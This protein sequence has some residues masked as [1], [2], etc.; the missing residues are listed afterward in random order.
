MTAA[1][2]EYNRGIVDESLREFT[3]LQT[4]RNVFAQ[5]WEEVAELILPTSRNTFFY[6][7]YNFPGQKKTDRQVD[8]TGALALERFTAILDSLMTPRNMT[9]HGLQAS[10]DDI[11]KDRRV[12]IWFEQVT[13]LLFKYRY[14][15]IANFSAQNANH[16][17][18]LGAFGNGNL[19]IDAYL[20]HDGSQGLRYRELP[21]GEMFLREN[22]QGQIDGFCRWF[23]MT[24]LQAIQMFVGRDPKEDD[25][26]RILGQKILE[27]AK[28]MSQ[29]P[30]D[31][32]HRVCPRDDYDPERYDVKGKRYA[33]Y[34]IGLNDR[35]FIREGGYVSFPVASSRYSQTPG[36]IYGRSPAMMVLPSLKTLNAEKKD[37]LTQGH[38]A[39]TP[40]YLGTD[41]GV[42]DFSMRPG[43]FNKGGMSEEG[44]PLVGV[45]PTGEIQVTKEMMDEERGLI[46][47]AF[48]TDLFKVLLGDPKIFTATQI[49]EMMSQRGILIAPAVGRQQSEYLGPMIERELDVLASARLLPPMPGLLR[50]AQGEFHVTY[51]SPL[52]R[53]MRAQE[54]AGFQ[55]TLEMATTIAQ[56]TQDP[57][58]LDRFDFD[59]AIPA[60]ATIQSVP[61]SWMSDDESIG[62]KRQARAQAQEQQ[63]QIQA[64]PAAAAMLKARAAQAKAGMT[65]EQNAQPQGQ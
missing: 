65:P 59:T 11:M 27:A 1:D 62:R 7:S 42:V 44:K 48:L 57:S 24:P 46:E 19:L 20:G 37:Y 38:R 2:D 32:L 26:K 22:H 53:E 30:Y 33:S 49:V 6:G 47:G 61:E 34:Y 15:P 36:E 56:T 5:H 39:G 17:Q 31:F 58:V 54:I 13:R 60:I 18:G 45:L 16:W 43:T 50:E 63:Q 41:D 28:Q 9:W 52:A 23:R 14:S 8:S 40:V 25:I 12:R 4:Y 51:A 35:Q 55:R 3:Q 21:L 10:N 64:A 29:M